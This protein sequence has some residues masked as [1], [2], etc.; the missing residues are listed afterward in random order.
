[1]GTVI[2]TGHFCNYSAAA[3]LYDVRPYN[4]TSLY[5]YLKR[6]GIMLLHSVII[7]SI[8]INYKIIIF[9]LFPLNS[10]ITVIIKLCIKIKK[11]F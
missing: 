10:I 8:I 7:I 5:I 6:G 9:N 4:A 2:I 3:L 1:M 11:S